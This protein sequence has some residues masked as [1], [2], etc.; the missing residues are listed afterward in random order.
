MLWM[1]CW[2]RVPG[3]G[4][5][6]QESLDRTAIEDSQVDTGRPVKREEDGKNMTARTGQLRQYNWDVT[7]MAGQPW[8]YSREDIWYRKA[9]VIV[10]QNSP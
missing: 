3:N 6:G 1:D 7:I 9:C 4:Q 2:E 10:G 8:Q 5:L